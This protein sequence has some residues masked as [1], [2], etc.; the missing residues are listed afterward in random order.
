MAYTYPFDPTGSV[1]T[2][3]VTNEIQVL[4]GSNQGDYYFIIPAAAPFFGDSFVLRYK[5]QQGITKTLVNGVDFHFGHMFI[6]AS[7]ACAK[8]VYG[9][10]VFV[11]TELKGVVSYDYQTIGGPWTIDVNEITRILAEHLANPRTTSWGSVTSLPYS[12]PVIDHEWE[13]DD[14]VGLSSLIASCLRIEQAILN[15][16][17][18]G[19]GGTAI[20]PEVLKELMHLE[21][22]PNF[23]AATQPEALAGLAQDRIMTPYLVKIVADQVRAYVDAHKNDHNNPHQITAAIIGALTSAD[24]ESRLSLLFDVNGAVATARNADKL[25]GK[26]LAQLMADVVTT[27]VNNA[28][29]SAKLDGK[30]LTEIYTQIGTMTV[31]GANKL[32]GKTLAEVFTDFALSTVE[33][34]NKLGGFTLA[35]IYEQISLMSVGDA[36]RL[37]GKSLAEVVEL[38]SQ[39]SAK[40]ENKTLAEVQ[41]QIVAAAKLET[42]A[43]SS[44][45]ENKSLQEVVDAATANTVSTIN[46]NF[47][48]QGSS[49]NT[50]G[51]AGPNYTRL[52]SLT[53]LAASQVRSDAVDHAIV[54]VSDDAGKEAIYLVRLKY[55]TEGNYTCDVI[56]ISAVGN[57]SDFRFGITQ[58]VNFCYLWL[59]T[60]VSRNTVTC[61][62][63]GQNF[64]TVAPANEP[65]AV[66]PG[67]YVALVANNYDFLV[68]LSQLPSYIANDATVTQLRADLDALADRLANAFGTL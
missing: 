66:Q 24:L 14:M 67:G 21:N 55:A 3:K 27:T 18:G 63:L 45:L 25:G 53:P 28:A 59:E 34:S 17:E 33:N 15:S 23:K 39:N 13:L 54:A 8:P 20:V 41:A 37:G 57:S 52:L 6:E 7:K 38:A 43:N 11:N 30:T 56:C 60:V 22:V 4:T 48:V 9:S 16:G 10:I 65:V 40:L 64:S 68:K 42:S 46:K 12:F 50:N 58:N 36:S 35:Q 51:L 1:S 62:L 29:N 61:T 44:K 2:N 47:A 26:S 19:G 32:G 5:D 49:P 31:E